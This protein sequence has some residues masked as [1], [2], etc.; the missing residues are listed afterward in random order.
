MVNVLYASVWAFAM[1]KWGDWKNWGKY[2]PTILFFII[3]DFLYLYLLSD[4]YPMWQY[5]P[6]EIDKQAGLT[7]THISLSIMVIKYP[8]TTL[9]YLSK[10]PRSLSKQFF[11]ILGWTCL[12]MINE[13]I[14]YK[15][16]LIQYSNGWSIKWSF[17]FNLTMFTILWIHYR[18]PILAWVMSILFILSLWQIFNVPS[19]VFR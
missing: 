15:T 1:W 5:H 18:R 17:V 4:L 11:Y 19:T 13:G 3:G 9:I 8:A 7:N 12:Y 14:D 16:G 6:P 2:Y 10:F